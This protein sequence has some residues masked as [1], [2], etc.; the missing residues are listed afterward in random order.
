GVHCDR[1]RRRADRPRR[2]S[3]HAAAGAC[4][5]VRGGA[6]PRPGKR[7]DMEDIMSDLT[8]KTTVV[9]GATRGLGHGIATAFAQA[10]GPVVAVGRSATA[11]EE[12]PG[13]TGSIQPE[14][15]DASES[16]A[17][18]R[19]LDRHDPQIVVLVAGATPHMRPLQHQTWE[20]FS[21]NWNTDV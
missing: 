17:A 5:T 15:A 20:T 11:P 7:P 1:C 13:G 16:T 9:V 12:L 3:P 14:L 21:V 18:A 19:L 10:G 2:P 4:R 8:G 6:V